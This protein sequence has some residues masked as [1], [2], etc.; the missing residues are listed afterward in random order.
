MSDKRI[1]DIMSDNKKK[2]A[3]IATVKTIISTIK[4]DHNA[5]CVCEPSAWNQQGKQTIMAN[6][7][8]MQMRFTRK[9]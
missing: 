9:K 8:T 1:G 7:N 3:A 5:N 6:R 4:I 2:A